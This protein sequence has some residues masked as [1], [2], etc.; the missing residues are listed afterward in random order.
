LTKQK[1]IRQFYP[2]NIWGSLRTLERKIIFAILVFAVTIWQNAIASNF[3]DSSE[4]RT[5]NKEKRLGQIFTP[6]YLVEDILDFAGYS[7]SNN[8]LE[9]HIIDNSCGDGAFLCEIVRRY[10]T[11]YS[12][13]HGES[14]RKKL[15]Q[16]LGAFIHGIEID[17]ISYSQCIGN[18]NRIANDFDLPPVAWD[19]QNADTM[20]ICKFDGCM[21]L[22]SAIHHMYE[23]TTSM[24]IYHV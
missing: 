15:A 19:I 17:A 6:Q 10:C 21:D 13:L 4:R 9:K 3:H 20:T 8:I 1:K 7:N 22:L 24:Q 18:L 11:A 2:D 14:N 5:V 16:Q 12:S 23:F